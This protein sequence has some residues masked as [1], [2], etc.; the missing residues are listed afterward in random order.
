MGI[1]ADKSLLF[2]VQEYVDYLRDYMRH[3]KLESRLR[4]EHKVVGV[5]RNPKGG[6]IVYYVKKDIGSD[7]W[8]SSK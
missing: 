2:L 6:H 1:C 3:F 4:L 5:V 8:E 7:A